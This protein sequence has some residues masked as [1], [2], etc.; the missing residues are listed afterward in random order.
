MLIK[1]NMKK[2]NHKVYHFIILGIY[3][4]LSILARFQNYILL[5]VPIILFLFYK[6]FKTKSQKYYKFILF[7]IIFLTTV[8]I[9]SFPIFFYH[10][11]YY[12]DPFFSGQ[13]SNF[14][15][16]DS[17]EEAHNASVQ[18][19][20]STFWEKHGLSGI[21]SRLF[22][23][24]Q[25]ALKTTEN[26]LGISNIFGGVILFLSILSMILLPIMLKRFKGKISERN[27]LIVLLFFNIHF[28]FAIWLIPNSVARVT[29]LPIFWVL[30]I[31]M[32][33]ILIAVYNKRVPDK[34]IRFKKITLNSGKL[35]F[36]ILILIVTLALV[37]EN[38]TAFLNL[39]YTKNKNKD[40]IEGIDFISTNYE[41]ENLNIAYDIYTSNNLMDFDVEFNSV[42]IL[43]HCS[44]I[45]NVDQYNQTEIEMSFIVTELKLL[46]LRN[47]SDRPH[48]K[49]QQ[50]DLFLKIYSNEVYVCL[51]NYILVFS[52]DTFKIFLLSYNYD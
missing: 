39:Q 34:N 30:I 16:A 48:S 50:I 33:I 52:R 19:S 25:L 7:L 2:Q 13:S 14:L 29:I 20:F 26:R 17:Y 6:F 40:Y 9:F 12:G 47:P 22:N 42:V 15:W 45:Q 35:K 11:Y 3:V 51:I 8:F 21:P 28:I 32:A 1:I 46:I 31:T 37:A 18:L 49:I 24:F 44:N 4:G 38:Y 36:S 5:T 23:G 43:E 27:D 10:N 41:I